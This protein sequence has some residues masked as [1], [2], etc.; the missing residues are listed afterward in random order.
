MSTL[1]LIP[2]PLPLEQGDRILVSH[3]EYASNVLAV[4]AASRRLGV[5][6]IDLYYQH[7]IGRAHV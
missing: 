5:E 7:Q 1:P 6:V 2:V 4:L 3:A